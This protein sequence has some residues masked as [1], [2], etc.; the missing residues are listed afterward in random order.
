[1]VCFE[2]IFC[3]YKT[4][5]VYL[6]IRS[7][8]FC[9]QIIRMHNERFAVPEV[10]FHPSDIGIQEMGVAE[11]LVHSISCCPQGQILCVLKF[12]FCVSSRSGSVSS[13]LGY[14]CPQGQVMSVLKVRFCVLKVKF[15]LS[16]RSD[17][18]CLQ[19]QIWCLQGQILSVLN[20]RFCVLKVRFCVL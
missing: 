6:V 5:V 19:G 13:R 9:W 15:Y 14:V 11:A 4:D 3:V 2:C 12:R 17:F 8:F 7:S 20:V 18:V 16:S 1:M 10:L